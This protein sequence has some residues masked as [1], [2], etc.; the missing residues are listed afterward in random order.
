MGSARDRALD[1]NRASGLNRP[2]RPPHMRRL[3]ASAIAPEAPPR[4]PEAPLRGD[5]GDSSP[6]QRSFSPPTAQTRILRANRSSGPGVYMHA[7]MGVRYRF[8]G[9]RT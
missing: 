4:P 1:P 5:A 9:D 8:L 2:L 7:L 6:T 3:P